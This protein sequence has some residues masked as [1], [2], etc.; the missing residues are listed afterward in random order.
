MKQNRRNF[1]QLTGTAATGAILS[2]LES[3][4]TEPQF[5]SKPIAGYELKILATNWGFDG[6]MDAFCAKAKKE[7]YDGIENW[8]P[9]TEKEQQEMFEAVN[10]KFKNQYISTCIR[11]GTISVLTIIENWLNMPL[12]YQKKQAFPSIMKRTG[13]E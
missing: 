9:G 5:S 12:L 7:G 10:K 3:F 2:S 13:E 4:A 6:S 11:A 8:W 1:L